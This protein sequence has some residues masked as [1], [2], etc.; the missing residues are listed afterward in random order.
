MFFKL[1][2]RIFKL[3]IRLSKILIDYNTA[4][5]LLFKQAVNLKPITNNNLQQ[6]ES[7]VKAIPL[8]L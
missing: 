1:N 7:I 2:I 8:G 6:E 5:L 4:K 3:H